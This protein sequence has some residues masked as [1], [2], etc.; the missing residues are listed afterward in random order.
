METPSLDLN[1][2]FNRDPLKLTR[3][4]IDVIIHHYRKAREAYLLGDKKAGTTATHKAKKDPP[5]NISLEDLG[6]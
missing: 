1:E 2:L 4:D 6:L 3:G 5:K